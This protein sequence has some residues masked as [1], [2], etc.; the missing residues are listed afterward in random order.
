MPYDIPG[1]RFTHRGDACS[2]DA[3]IADF[4][5]TDA[6]L[7]ELAKI[8]R[9]ADTGHLNQSPQAPGLAAISL[10]LSVM[11][12]NDHEMLAHGMTVYDA[13]YAWLRSAR[14]EVHNAD[15][16]SRARS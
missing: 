4:G 12:P 1:V 10:G 16:F 9:A 13:L 6:A 7:G 8:V 2:F 5:L 3:F 15:L 11:Y 14:G